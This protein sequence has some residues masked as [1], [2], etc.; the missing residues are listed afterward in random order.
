MYHGTW[1]GKF[2]PGAVLLCMLA[3]PLRSRGTW[4]PG[5]APGDAT[6]CRKEVFTRSVNLVGLHILRPAHHLPLGCLKY[7]VKL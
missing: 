3:K 4:G 2:E 6:A 5:S 1:I 7:T